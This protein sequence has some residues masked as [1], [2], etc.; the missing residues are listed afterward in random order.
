[1]CFVFVGVTNFFPTSG[2]RDLVV[3]IVGKPEKMSSLKFD[4]KRFDGKMNFSIWQ[5]SMKDVLVQQG[6][7]KALQ[8]KKPPSMTVDE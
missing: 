3:E 4:I 8:G 6:L 5:N 7:L 2:I 1:M